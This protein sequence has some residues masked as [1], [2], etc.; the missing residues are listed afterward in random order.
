MDLALCTIHFLMRFPFSF[1]LFLYPARTVSFHLQVERKYVRK[2]M[3][4]VRERGR[5]E[6]E[7]TATRVKK[8]TFAQFVSMSLTRGRTSSRVVAVATGSTST[9]WISVSS[10]FSIVSSISTQITG[11]G[12]Q[13]RK[14]EVVQCPVCRTSWQNPTTSPSKPGGQSFLQVSIPVGEEGGA[15]GGAIKGAGGLRLKALT[16]SQQMNLSQEKVLML[17]KIRKVFSKFCHEFL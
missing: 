4:S 3:E 7:G 6:R 11:A 14:E 16:P 17:E 15:V 5:R 12:E 10:I 1:C 8:K 13:M 2:E 9:A